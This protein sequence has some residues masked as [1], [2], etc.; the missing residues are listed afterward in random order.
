MQNGLD[1]ANVLAALSLLKWK[2]EHCFEI[3]HEDTRR[4]WPLSATISPICIGEI[5]TEG[6]NDAPCQRHKIRLRPDANEYPATV[7]TAI[8]PRSAAASA[9]RRLAAV[10][11]ER[12]VRLRPFWGER[13]WTIGHR[14]PPEP[15]RHLRPGG[16]RTRR[17]H[18]RRRSDEK[19]VEVGRY[20]RRLRGL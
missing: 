16:A 15:G 4:G 20:A 5:V 9:P 1:M 19:T 12:S 14:E 2:C 7:G 6:V 10:A 8:R 18:V 13:P 11:C 17:L 3:Q